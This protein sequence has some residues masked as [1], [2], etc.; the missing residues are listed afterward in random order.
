MKKMC[1]IISLTL[2]AGLTFASTSS[3]LQKELRG[4]EANALV[5]QSNQIILNTPSKVPSFF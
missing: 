2:F 5:K 4:L 1:S 3:K